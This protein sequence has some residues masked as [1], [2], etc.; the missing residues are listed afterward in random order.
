MGSTASEWVRSRT[1]QERRPK[2]DPVL[3]E[4]LKSELHRAAPLEQTDS[5]VQVDVM[6]RREHERALGVI[7]RTLEPCMTPLLDPVSLGDVHDLEFSRRHFVALP[8][9]QWGIGVTRV[10]VH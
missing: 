7:P 10:F 1:P 2:P 3:Q 8:F 6:A 5:L 4:D 9:P